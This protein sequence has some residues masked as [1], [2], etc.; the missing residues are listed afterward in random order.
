M[1]GAYLGPDYTNQE[2]E[3]ILDNKN[4]NSVHGNLENGLTKHM[5][6]DLI[7]VNGCLLEKPQ[8]LLNQLDINGNLVC[9]EKLGENLKKIV[10]YESKNKLIQR[11]EF[12]I[13][14]APILL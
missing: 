5:P 8:N 11:K 3:L 6:Y 9:I 14:N 4:I 1:K 10:R 13:V 2:I 7:F 12:S